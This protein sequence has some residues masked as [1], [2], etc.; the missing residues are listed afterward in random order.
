MATIGSDV[1]MLT[2][3]PSSNSQPFMPAPSQRL[4]RRADVNA[5][6]AEEQEMARQ[7][8]EMEA[9]AAGNE[10]GVGEKRQREMTG[11]GYAG[12]GNG[13]AM[14]SDAPI[15]DVE[16][17]LKDVRSPA[18]RGRMD[19]D[20]DSAGGRTTKG[21]VCLRMRGFQSFVV[22]TL[23]SVFCTTRSKRSIQQL[24]K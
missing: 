6:A 1:S 7:K 12:N 16:G 13:V 5:R 14:G 21:G 18:K 9:A 23:L 17:P 22:E 20:G 15:E 4:A 11:N 24:V 8:A 2:S 19:V 10:P 3:F